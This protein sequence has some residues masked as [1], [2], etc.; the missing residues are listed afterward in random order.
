[1]SFIGEYCMATRRFDSFAARVS[2]SR[3]RACNSCQ[4]R[5]TSFLPGK[6]VEF[7][8]LDRLHNFHRLARGRDVVEPAARRE[9]L[10]VQLQNPVGEGIAVPE[11][12]EE[13]AVQFGVAQGSLN[14]SHPFCRRLL[15]M[16]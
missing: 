14:F 6:R 2:T 15:C 10:F 3:S 12:V 9:H 13:P 7:E 4:P 16:H 8:L 11:I 1:M 5:K